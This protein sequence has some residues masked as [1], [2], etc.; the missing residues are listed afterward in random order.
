MKTPATLAA[1]AVAAAI[2][3]LPAAALA[4]PSYA[5]PDRSQEI[6][7]TVASF[8]GHDALT[9]RDAHGYLDNV[10]LHQGTIINPTGLTLAPGMPVTIYGYAAGPTFDANEID[11]PYQTAY[12]V[13]AYPYP[14]PAFGL[15]IGIGFGGFG[16]HGYGR[17]R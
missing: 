2:A 5:S 4:Q 11:T 14:G 3:A 6:S 1:A 7:G 13:P 16:F 17:F 15:G 10:T 9:V 8:D 12:L